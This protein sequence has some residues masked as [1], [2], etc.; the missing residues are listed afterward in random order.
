MYSYIKSTWHVTRSG[1]VELEVKTFHHPVAT[2]MLAVEHLT[3]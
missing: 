1:E 2:G 3:G